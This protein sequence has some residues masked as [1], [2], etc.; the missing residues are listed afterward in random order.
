[1]SP[2]EP[3]AVRVG[4]A[5]GAF[6]AI[7]DQMG[8]AL[9]R[10]AHSANIKERRDCST[11]V[12][13]PEG[14]LVMQAEHIPVHLGSMPA[15]VAEVSRQDQ[16]PGRSWFLNDPYHGGSHLPDLT[17]V[18]PAFGSDGTL[19][20]YAAN[21]AHHADVGGTT[22]GSMPADSRTLGEEGVVI[23]PRV[24]DDR[25]IDEVVA[26]MRQPEQRRADLRAQLAA[27][28]IGTQGLGSLEDRF[29]PDGLAGRMA[30]VIE[31]AARRTEA[32]IREIPDGTYSARDFLEGREGDL[33]LVLEVTVEGDRLRYDFTGSSSSDPG[34]LNCPRS[35]TEAACYFATRVIA[36]PDA[37][38]S[39]GTFRPVEVVT[40]PGSLLEAAAPAAVVAGNVET[41]SR[42][43]DL[44]LAA[45]GRALG[46]GTMN[47]VTMGNDRFTYYETIAGGQGAFP[48]SD[49]PDAVQVAMSNT[50]NTPIEALEIE[51]PMRVTEYSVRRESGGGGAS[52][53]GDGVVREFEALE[54]MEFSLLTERRR[55]QPPGAEQGLPGELGL[56]LLFRRDSDQP[57]TLLSKDSGRLEAGD[58]LRLETPGGGGYGAP[59][60]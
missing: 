38:A 59:G 14:N 4:L 24:L 51:F 60:G 49:G 30:E 29:G 21:R 13:D 40:T 32:A 12:F 34:N 16:A 41:S 3:Q 54:P 2:A 58:T 9:V 46:Q 19:I 37:P 39:S 52:R 27:N 57:V 25:A 20:G 6:G 31:Y 45:F 11:A 26:L 17:V 5:A 23:P 42:V 50:L 35:V 1:M 55:H 47:N 48:G 15:S 18:T 43:A 53:G 36:D 28:S 7:C 10:A 8:A 56:N 22:P 33:E 44:C